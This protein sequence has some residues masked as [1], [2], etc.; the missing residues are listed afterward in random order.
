MAYMARTNSKKYTYLDNIYVSGFDYS[1]HLNLCCNAAVLT[2]T[3][4]VAGIHECLSEFFLWNLGCGQVPL[5]SI[6]LR[7]L[8]Y[9]FDLRF[10]LGKCTHDQ[11]LSL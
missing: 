2:G 1:V 11:K 6:N 3:R 10:Y 7:A 4:L 5:R 9:M 8:A